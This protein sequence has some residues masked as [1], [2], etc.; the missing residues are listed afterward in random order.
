[1]ALQ[2]EAPTTVIE[3]I[4][5][6]AAASFG[7]Y[8]WWM[9]TAE[10]PILQGRNRPRSL[11]IFMSSTGW[12]LFGVILI[13]V[14]LGHLCKHYFIAGIVIN[15]ITLAYYAALL[16]IL[17]D[18]LSDRSRHATW[19][20]KY[21]GYYPGKRE[22]VPATDKAALYEYLS[23]LDPIESAAPT[24]PASSDFDPRSDGSIL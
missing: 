2:P 8:S 1:M 7:R 19:T 15:A 22:D 14:S 21:T 4:V 5:L 13:A 12:I 24:N 9:N 17:S 11:F 6:P 23:V 18:L 10:R 3:G 16:W 20:W